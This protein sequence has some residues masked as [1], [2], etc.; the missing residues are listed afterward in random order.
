[1]L[2][3]I[4]TWHLYVS[5]MQNANIYSGWTNLFLVRGM[6]EVES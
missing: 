5:V 1:M 3:A 6:D 2:F 4:V